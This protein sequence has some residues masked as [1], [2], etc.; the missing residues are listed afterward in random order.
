MI[1][2]RHKTV[3]MAPGDAISTCIPPFYSATVNTNFWANLV[4]NVEL[5]PGLVT[6]FIIKYTEGTSGIE[7]LESLREARVCVNTEACSWVC[8]HAMSMHISTL[9]MHM[10][11]PCMGMHHEWLMHVL[12]NGWIYHKCICTCEC[13]P[14]L[15]VH[16][17]THEYI[18]HTYVWTSIHNCLSVHIWTHDCIC[19][20]C[21]V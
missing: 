5:K 13:L 9:T 19:H 8:T 12:T 18:C 7:L 15:S 3:W 11:V 16:V 4:S 10:C 6:S 20:V 1:C 14:H 2:S 17:C 21:I